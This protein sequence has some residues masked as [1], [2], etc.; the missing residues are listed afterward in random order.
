LHTQSGLEH[1]KNIVSDSL[2]SRAVL[3]RRIDRLSKP[4]QASVSH[5]VATGHAGIDR[6]LGGGLLRGKLHEIIGEGPE[7]A[8]SASGFTAICARLIG[9]PIAW[10]RVKADRHLL[11]P[12]GLQEIGLD[13]PRMVLVSTPHSAALLRAADD[14]MR[15]SALGA[16]VIE[17]WREPQRIDL[18]ASRRLVLSAEASGVT[19]LLLR[20]GTVPLPTAAQTRWAVCPAPSSPMAANAPGFPALDL[21]LLRQRGG[22]AG[23][24]WR[25][26]W[27]RDAASLQTPL[28]GAVDAVPAHR[29]LADDAGARR[30]GTG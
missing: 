21:N 6:A 13:P 16:V 14:A 11:Y 3:Q 7:N 8:A 9:G 17:L 2:A 19:A 5:K 24:S 23:L 22:P 4:R 27:N 12:H 25:V 18:T 29:P 26:E 1:N 28:S 30:Y 15:C 10:L 20:I